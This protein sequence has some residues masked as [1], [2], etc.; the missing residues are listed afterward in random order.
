MTDEQKLQTIIH[1]LQEFPLRDIKL[2]N[3]Q[4]NPEFPLA[5]FIL[6]SC[7]LDQMSGFRYNNNNV[8]Y[9]YKQFIIDYMPQY[10]AEKIYRDIRCRLV[11]NYSTTK[12]FSLTRHDPRHLHWYVTIVI[13]SATHFILDIENA[14]QQFSNDIL[15]DPKAK[16][17]AIAWY[18]KYNILQMGAN[19]SSL[20]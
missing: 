17:N 6:C 18:D 19:L 16:R 10:D 13:L 1:S 8:G 2:I 4:T 9:R 3:Q 12:F 15:K 11:H 5:T 14:F 7:F 20:I